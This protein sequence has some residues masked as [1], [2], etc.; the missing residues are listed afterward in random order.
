MRT[1]VMLLLLTTAASAQMRPPP[2]Q[3]PNNPPQMRAPGHQPV[4]AH[5]CPVG[6]TWTYG[7]L[8]YG[9]AG[10]G[11]LFGACLRSGFSCMRAAG[12]IQ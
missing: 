11:Q 2:Q 5:L 4:G 1:L 12:P 7:C 9:P 10:P 3:Q 6:Q 8:A